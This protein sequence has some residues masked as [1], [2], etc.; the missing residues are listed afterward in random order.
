[1]THAVRRAWERLSLYLPLLLLALMAV[2]TWWLVRNAPHPV[3]VSQAAAPSDVPDYTMQE[4]SV[5]QFNPQGRLVSDI[6]GKTARHFPGNDTLEVDQVRTRGWAQD[7]TLTMTSAQRGL[8][9]ADGS[10]VQ[11]WGDAQVRRIYAQGAK[12]A[13]DLLLAGEFLHAWT[14]EEKVSTHLPVRMQRGADHFTAN[15]M[16]YDHLTQVLQLQGRVKGTLFPGKR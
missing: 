16:T 5:H 4:F 2:A 9:N 15:A 7:G 11:L 1:M 6:V 3:V 8:S 14:L 10:E 12:S 13:P